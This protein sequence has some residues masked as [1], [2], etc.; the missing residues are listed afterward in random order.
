[1]RS[2]KEEE[3]QEQE[4]EQEL[5]QQLA[6]SDSSR[7][8]GACRMASRNRFSGFC[9]AQMRLILNTRCVDV[10]SYLIHVNPIQ[11]ETI[12]MLNKQRS[13]LTWDKSNN[14][15]DLFIQR[16]STFDC[17]TPLHNP[18]HVSLSNCTSCMSSVLSAVVAL[19][20]S[21]S[22]APFFGPCVVGRGALRWH[23]RYDRNKKNKKRKGRRRRRRRRRRRQEEEEEEEEEQEEEERKKKKKKSTNLEPLHARQIQHT[24][25][26]GV[27]SLQQR[28]GN[29]DALYISTKRTHN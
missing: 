8:T 11:L 25:F 15:L 10:F 7:T 24:Q 3:Q 18:F 4:Q 29:L 26:A 16:N 13:Q 19:R 1:M 22:A 6:L 27:Q 5:K 28:G 14:P 12:E 21:A 20:Y 9:P 17:C 23:N 2:V